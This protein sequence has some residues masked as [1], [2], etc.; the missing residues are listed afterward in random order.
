MFQ[1]CDTDTGPTMTLSAWHAKAGAGFA[2]V[3]AVVAA[4]GS[5][6]ADRMID[7][8]YDH[9]I[10][11]AATPGDTRARIAPSSPLLRLTSATV[12]KFGPSHPVAA[13]EHV[14]LTAPA[15]EPLPTA[16]SLPAEAK[17]SVVATTIGARFTIA[18]AGVLQTMEVVDVR[19]VDGDALGTQDAVGHSKLLLVSCKA[20]SAE[21]TT[22]GTR[23]VRFLIDALP[24]DPASGRSPR[25]L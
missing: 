10:A 17:A 12:V 5:T 21:A 4:V 8:G 25:A 1:R 19:P 3:A 11:V 7:R 13:A 14:W 18:H 15:A 24:V 22:A 6:G 23:L 16:E 9:A 2:A 20:V